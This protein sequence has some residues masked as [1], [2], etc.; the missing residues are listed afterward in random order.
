M[1]APR[2]PNVQLSVLFLPLPNLLQR[3]IPVRVGAPKFP[4]GFN[5][6]L[7]TTNASGK[8]TTV[9]SGDFTEPH[10]HPTNYPVE[11]LESCS[12]SYD[13]FRGTS[14][15]D[16]NNSLTLPPHVVNDER[17]RTASNFP[18]T[19]LYFLSLRQSH[20]LWWIVDSRDAAGSSHR[21]GRSRTSFWRQIVPQSRRVPS[22]SGSSDSCSSRTPI[23]PFC[24]GRLQLGSG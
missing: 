20:F 1:P 18:S 10:R 4:P 14:F 7:L 21:R 16:H 12:A 24:P 17:T 11:R 6:V 8:E 15:C 19:L 13:S 5:L 22:S 2:F 23:E 3:S 9:Q